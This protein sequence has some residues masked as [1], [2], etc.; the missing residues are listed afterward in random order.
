MKNENTRWWCEELWTVKRCWDL[1]WDEWKQES[2]FAWLIFAELKVELVKN[3]HL[4]GLL[5][6]FSISHHQNNIKFSFVSSVTK[7]KCRKMR[8]DETIFSSYLNEI[9]LIMKN[10]LKQSE[11]ACEQSSCNESYRRVRGSR[12][13]HDEFRA[14]EDFSYAGDTRKHEVITEERLKIRNIWW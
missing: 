12:R 7:K 3:F 11:S 10:E 6:K 2:K 8:V 5:M 9:E 14:K 13:C 1:R 4:S